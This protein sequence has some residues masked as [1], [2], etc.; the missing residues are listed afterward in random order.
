MYRRS[1][2]P[3]PCKLVNKKRISVLSGSSF[4][5]SDNLNINDNVLV[6]NEL[7][8]DQTT[9]WNNQNETGTKKYCNGDQN[10]QVKFI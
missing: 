6:N 4:S 7:Q 10:I 3:G 1:K 2:F 5:N 9:L 8:S